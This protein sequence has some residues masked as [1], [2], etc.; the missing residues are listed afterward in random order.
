MQVM[1]ICIRAGGNLV[2]TYPFPNRWLFSR[3]KIGSDH[4]PDFGEMKQY[5]DEL[6]AVG[7]WEIWMMHSN[8]GYM[9]DAYIQAL[10]QAIDYCGTVGVKIVTAKEALDFYGLQSQ[11]HE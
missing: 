6:V 1:R 10:K 3:Y 4:V 5:I 9:T 8:N 2:N 11:I 7:G